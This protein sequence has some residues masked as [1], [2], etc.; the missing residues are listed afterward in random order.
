VVHPPKL[1]RTH[2]FE[3]R[4]EI[5]R[6]GRSL[7]NTD[8]YGQPDSY[9]YSNA[10]ARSYSNSYIYANAYGDDN[11]DYDGDPNSYAYF[12]TE[13]FTYTKDNPGAEGSTYS[14]A[15]PV[16]FELITSNQFRYP[17]VS[18]AAGEAI[19]FVRSLSRYSRKEPR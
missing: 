9:G 19:R 2:F 17:N 13:T 15:A 12:D 11:T 8:S 16:T 3:H 18:V 1:R 7:A 5:L 14:A 10:D 4:R 6:A